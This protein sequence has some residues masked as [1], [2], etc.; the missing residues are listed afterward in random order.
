[1]TETDEFREIIDALGTEY[2]EI[3]MNGAA[4][5]LFCFP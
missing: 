2:P 5:E 1:M 4:Q 3:F